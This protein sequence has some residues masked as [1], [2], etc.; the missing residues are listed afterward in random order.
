VNW[1]L[2]PGVYRSCFPE[3]DETD[4]PRL[5]RHLNQDFRIQAAALIAGEKNDQ[6]LYFLQQHYGI[7]T[8]LLDWSTNPLAP[9]SCSQPLTVRRFDGAVFMMDAY[10]LAVCQGAQDPFLG[11]ATSRLG[12]FKQALRPI[13]AWESE[14]LF[15]PFIIPVC[16]NHFD[17]RVMLQRS[18]FTFH[19]PM[20][21]GLTRAEN[22]LAA[23]ICDPSKD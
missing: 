14:D 1:P 10:Q 8:R 11:V 22:N 7:P 23:N 17:R 3:K 18:G 6:E 5:E 2:T 16:P 19:P 12:A 13:C 15:P 21:R 20:R 9:P 4:R